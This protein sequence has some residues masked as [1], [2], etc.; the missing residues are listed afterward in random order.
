VYIAEQLLISSAVGLQN[1]RKKPFCSTFA[2]FFSRSYDQIRMGAISQANIKL[3]GSHAGVSIGEDGPSQMA[4]E[5]LSM[6]RSIYGSTVLYPSDAT[7]TAALVAEMKDLPGISFIRTTRE[8]TPVLYGPDEKFPVGGSKTLR[9]SEN[10]V[11]TVIGA[12]I[13]VREALTAYDTL[14]ASGKSIRVLDLYSVKPIDRASIVKAASETGH[15][16]VVEDH[17]SEGGI[18]EATLAALAQAHGQG[19]LEGHAAKFTHLCVTKMPRSG[20]PD[21]LLKDNGISAEDIVRAVGA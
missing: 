1:R 15:L 16:I 2:A 7:S 19:E 11:A 13:T 14:Q 8:A 12:G 4:L 21:E 20:K 9:S 5:D 3:C 17:W 10:D 18:G 6:M